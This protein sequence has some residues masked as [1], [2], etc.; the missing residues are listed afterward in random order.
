M[1]HMEQCV[2]P[3]SLAQYHKKCVT[4]VEQ[5]A[6]VVHED[7]ILHR[8]LGLDPNAVAMLCGLGGFKAHGGVV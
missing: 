8:F 6:A 4:K 1:P 5:L 3:R 2:L 7:P